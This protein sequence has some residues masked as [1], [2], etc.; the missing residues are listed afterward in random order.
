[1]EPVDYKAATIRYSVIFILS[2]MISVFVVIAAM[3][4]SDQE[5][6][7][8]GFIARTEELVEADSPGYNF[9]NFLLNAWVWS[10]FVI[11]LMNQRLEPL[12]LYGWHG[13]DSDRMLCQSR[14]NQRRVDLSGIFQDL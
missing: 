1:M 10:E 2:A 5:Y 13:R 12:R 3:N 4:M 14:S 11:M 9:L 7:S 6:F 8:L